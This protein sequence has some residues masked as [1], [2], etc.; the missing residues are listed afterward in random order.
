MSSS[1]SLVAIAASAVVGFSLVAT[2]FLAPEFAIAAEASTNTSPPAAHDIP[3]KAPTKPVLSQ[4]PDNN[5]GG[6][7]GSNSSSG[8]C[9]CPL[10]KEKLWSR[11]K[12]ADLRSTLD[13]A[14]EVAALESVQVA[15]S[16][17]GDGSSYVWHRRN[18][19]LSG[20][21]QP[22][23]SFKDAAGQV[24]RHIVVVLSAGSDSKRA[25]GIACRL[26]NGRWQLEG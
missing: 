8:S 23:S 14:D 1:S 24:C 26:T 18:G 2:I 25:E 21:V 22:T 16:E 7:S 6:N 19:R 13:E 9:T 17:V 5:S 11:P 20:I 15:L 10:D 4:K 12:F 3:N